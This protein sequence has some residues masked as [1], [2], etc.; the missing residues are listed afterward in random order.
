MEKRQRS[1]RPARSGWTR[2][3][4]WLGMSFG[5]ALGL[6]LLLRDPGPDRP[7]WLE[8]GLLAG[9]VASAG[10]WV[11]AHYKARPYVGDPRPKGGRTS[12]LLPFSL[13]WCTAVLGAAGMTQ[14]MLPDRATAEWEQALAQA[15]GGLRAATVV[16]V[17]GTPLDTGTSINEV[18][19]YR[20]TIVFAVP[21]T[22]GARQVTLDGVETTGLPEPGT[23]ERLAFAPDRPDLGV[24]TAEAIGF[25]A[26]SAF[27]TVWIWA[28]NGFG[29]VFATI[30]MYMGL[31]TVDDARRYQR[32][33]H[34]PSLVAFGLGAAALLPFLF[35]HPSGGTGFLLGLVAMLAPWAGVCRAWWGSNEYVPWGVQDEV[36]VATSSVRPQKAH[37][38]RLRK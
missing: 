10:L 28:L 37:T 17:V 7:R 23:K 33:V 4:G 16:R 5:W 11:V 34:L 30:G 35:G 36:P 18:T 32:R 8:L 2:L 21:F 20:S 12:Y 27:G 29:G 25:D 15:G 14:V 22:A 24:R 19:V 6:T 13:A 26:G 9:A 3:T 38:P 1:R 31:D